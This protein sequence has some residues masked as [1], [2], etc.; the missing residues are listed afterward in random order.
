MALSNYGELKTEL[1]SLL[2]RTDLTTYLPYFI[3]YA[4]TVIGGD[5]EPNSMDALPG[6]RVRG[7]QKRV[8]TATTTQY[9]DVPT[10][11]LSIKDIQINTNPTRNL[12]YLSPKQMTEKFPSNPAGTPSHYTLHGDEIQFSHVPDSSLTLEISYVSRYAAFSGDT[13]TNWL[14]TNH[15]FAYLYAAM[16][17]GSAHIDEDP[18]KWGAMYKSIANGINQSSNIASNL[19]LTRAPLTDY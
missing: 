6:I 7:Q 3:Q 13:D 5:P 16:V 2:H 15:P 8:T 12:I 1:A 14:L 10:D 4:E 11:M 9:L 17:A 18:S 19:G